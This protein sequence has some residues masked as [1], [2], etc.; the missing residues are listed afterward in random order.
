MAETPDFERIGR[1]LA[2]S[3]VTSEDDDDQVTYEGGQIAAA[4][5]QAWNARG[6]ADID[7]AVTRLST[8]VG[9]V[10]SEPYL[11]YIREA[12]AALDR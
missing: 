12:I 3:F 10:S 8:L 7:A 9:W 11:K 6:A 1:A 5:R 4:L 2:S